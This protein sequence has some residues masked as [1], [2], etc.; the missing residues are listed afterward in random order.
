LEREADLHVALMAR[1][2]IERV[3]M[4][5]VCIVYGI[6]WKGVCDLESYAEHGVLGNRNASGMKKNTG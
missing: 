5:V 4:M 3:D 2:A 6:V 1:K